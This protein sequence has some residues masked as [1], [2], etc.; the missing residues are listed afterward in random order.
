MPNVSDTDNEP[1]TSSKLF[2]SLCSR[3]NQLS[4]FRDRRDW[5]IC[6]TYALPQTL[7]PFVK[8]RLSWEWCVLLQSPLVVVLNY[9]Y[10]PGAYFYNRFWFS[11]TTTTFRV[12]KHDDLTILGVARTSM[13]CLWYSFSS[14]TTTF[15][16]VKHDDLTFL[17]VARTS[18]ITL[19]GMYFYDLPLY[20][21][22]TVL[23]VAHTSMIHFWWSFSSVT[24]IFHVSSMMTQPSWEG[25]GLLQSL[26]VVIL[27]YFYFLDVYFYNHF[28]W[29]FSTTTFQ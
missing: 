16:V 15:C 29:L 10:F 17:G 14:I 22:S 3:H 5:G 9:Y 6:T 27:Y 7:C 25:Q 1:T 11:T 13:I 24:T 12:V 20:D 26:L 28:C 19:C 18:M 8:T 2:S 21:D 23:G 4:T